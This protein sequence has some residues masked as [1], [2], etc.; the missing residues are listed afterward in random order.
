MATLKDLSRRELEAMV[1]GLNDAIQGR[2]SPFRRHDREVPIVLITRDDEGDFIARDLT[3]DGCV[4]HA[5]TEHGAYEHLQE[6]RKQYDEALESPESV[7]AV[8][9]AVEAKQS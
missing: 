4:C 5:D 8:G 3:R 9:E 7:P 2:I 6:A 1:L